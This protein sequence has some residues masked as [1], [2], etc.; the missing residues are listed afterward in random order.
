[1]ISPLSGI[2]ERKKKETDRHICYYL[3][4]LLGYW[5]VC[6]PHMSF[7]SKPNT[8][9]QDLPFYHDGIYGRFIMFPCGLSIMGILSL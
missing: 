1:M 3:V 5:V 6:E 4:Y 2:P 9:L 8:V 7:C